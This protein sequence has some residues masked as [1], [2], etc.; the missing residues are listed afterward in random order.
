MTGSAVTK[1][2]YLAMGNYRSH[3]HC[4]NGSKDARRSRSTS[5]LLFYTRVRNEP[6][7]GDKVIDSESEPGTCKGKRNRDGI[8]NDRYLALDVGAESVDQ[9]RLFVVASNQ[10]I[11]Q[12]V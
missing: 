11:R 12:E 8:G 1:L 10:R 6:F 7:D 2:F 3:R 9:V 5:Y 4:M